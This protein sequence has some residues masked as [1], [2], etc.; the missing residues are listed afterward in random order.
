MPLRKGLFFAKGTGDCEDFDKKC[1]TYGQK[2]PKF[3]TISY[4]DATLTT[5]R[6]LDRYSAFLGA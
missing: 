3:S 2:R 5:L 1:G 4:S 6:G